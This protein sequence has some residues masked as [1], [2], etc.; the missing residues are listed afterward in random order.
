V[1]RRGLLLL[2]VAY[3][4]FASW[5]VLSSGWTA[6]QGNG[7]ILHVACDPTRELWRDLN[8]AFLK[9]AGPGIR[10]RQSHGGS[11]SQARAI[12]DGLEADVASLALW[13]DIDVLQQAGRLNTGWEERWP[14]RSMPYTSTI[15][16]VVRKGNPKQIMDW[17]D[18]AREDVSVIVPNPKTSGNGKWAFLALWGYQKR[19][20]ATDDQATEFLRSLFRR[21]PVLDASAR[22]A[23]MTFAQKRI[24]DVHITWENEA[25]LE[26]AEAQGELEIITPKVS[27]LA[28]PPIAIM[29][30]VVDQ[31]GTR[32]IVTKYMEFLY[33]ERAQKIIAHHHLRPIHPRVLASAGFPQVELFTVREIDPDWNRLHQRFFAEGA[34]FDS[35]FAGRGGS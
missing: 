32:D 19:Q 28:E 15:V 24:G 25:Y 4:A 5:Y 23:T 31:K 29:D 10:I 33:T 34:L 6:G 21:V 27:I 13:T 17:H 14:N 35:F 11:A 16:L 7:E 1:V 2:V 8:R 9:D 22:G 30:Q 3:L 26:V 20:G 12:M 18:L